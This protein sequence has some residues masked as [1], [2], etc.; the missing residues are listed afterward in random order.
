[1][2]GEA[3]Q[4]LTTRSGF[5]FD[6]RPVR[7]A[8]EQSFGDFFRH[9]TPQD[10]R[11][12]FL[13]TRKIDDDLIRGMTRVDH[14]LS[15]RFVALLPGT[16]TVIASALLAT[17]P[18]RE[19]GEVA[20]AIRPEYKRRG[21]SWTLLEHV[22]R[23]AAARGFKRIESIESRDNEAAI[24]LEQEM[25]FTLSPIEGEPTLVLVTLDL[26]PGMASPPAA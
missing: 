6:V 5:A 4:Q 15:E 2:D 25:G 18:A 10:L 20:V 23:H 26:D 7:A 16:D 11:F 17:D 24:S 3:T 13:S 21:I 19:R 1:M 14:D 8:D 9:L 22:T 12:R